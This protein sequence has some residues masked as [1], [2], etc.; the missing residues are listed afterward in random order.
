MNSYRLNQ[1]QHYQRQ[2]RMIILQII[3][4]AIR[5]QCRHFCTFTSFTPTCNF[6]QHLH[7]YHYRDLTKR[8][9]AQFG[10]FILKTTD[11]TIY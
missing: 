6:D 11:W 4:N 1:H 10:N 9:S 5:F 8:C 2:L 3:G 7:K